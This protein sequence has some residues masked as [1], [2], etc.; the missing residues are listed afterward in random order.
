MGIAEDSVGVRIIRGEFYAFLCRLY[1]L[2][3]LIDAEVNGTLLHEVE[4][5][6]WCELHGL[7]DVVDGLL[8]HPR[9][10]LQLASVVIECVAH[11]IVVEIAE[12]VVVCHCLSVFTFLLVDFRPSQV[13]GSRLLW[14]RVGELRDGR[15]HHGNLDVGAVAR[16]LM[17]EAACIECAWALVRSGIDLI[18]DGDGTA[19][20]F[21]RTE[22]LCFEQRI[23]Q[24][25]RLGKLLLC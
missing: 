10:D 15:V 18:V 21:L 9:L 19:V 2:V 22:N 13:V 4:R 25:R 7:V 3:D 8:I 24:L 1:A 20:V 23:F 6:L 16:R 17:S 14:F 11:L 12:L 5:V